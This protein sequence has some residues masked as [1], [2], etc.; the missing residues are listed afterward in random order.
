[1]IIL[2]L[3][4]NLHKSE[5]SHK[6]LDKLKSVL[7][8][9]VGLDFNESRAVAVST[10]YAVLSIVERCGVDS[11]V[12]AESLTLNVE[13]GNMRASA[14]EALARPRCS[15]FNTLVG[16]K[17]VFDFRVVILNEA[18]RLNISCKEGTLVADSNLA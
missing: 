14:L 5:R 10:A 8:L 18:F 3:A 1:M 16:E 9:S 11:K 2:S 12:E 17:G 7:S 6:H 4:L 13:L 15:R